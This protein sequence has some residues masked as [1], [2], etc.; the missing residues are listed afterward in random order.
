VEEGVVEQQQEQAQEDKLFKIPQDLETGHEALL[1]AT[2]ADWAR[3]A[4][5]EIKGRV[6]PDARLNT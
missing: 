4:V 1:V 5:K 3:R 6:C 2:Q